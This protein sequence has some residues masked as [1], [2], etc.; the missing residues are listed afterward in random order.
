MCNDGIPKVIYK[1]RSWEESEKNPTEK[2]YQRRI[3]THS[4][5]YFTNP[6]NFNDPFEW[7]YSQK[8]EN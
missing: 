1:Y 7:I 4:E 5:V 2:K 3:L 6:T 8:F